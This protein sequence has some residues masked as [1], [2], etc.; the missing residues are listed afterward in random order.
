MLFFP[1]CRNLEEER[2]QEVKGV[3]K[4]QGARVG[5]E[6]KAVYIRMEVS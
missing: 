2:R 1:K 5:K 4:W 3:W 6:A